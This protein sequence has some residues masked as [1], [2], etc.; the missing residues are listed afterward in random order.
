LI[1]VIL[2]TDPRWPIARVE[3]V[4]AGAATTLGGL[5][6]FAVQLRDKSATPER[7]RADALRL[8]ALT[9]R[10]GARLVVNA[11]TPAHLAVAVDVGADGAHV[12]CTAPSI[13]RAREALGGAWISTPAHTRNDVAL[14][15]SSGADAALVS[16]IFHTPGKGSERGV[17]ALREARAC[18][19]G[20][21][22]ASRLRLYAL[23]GVDASRAA[24]CAEA[25]AD[26]VAVIRALLDA[27]DPEREAELL[28]AP[29][30]RPRP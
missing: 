1:T 16:P 28:D 23:G 19:E 18:V 17:D 13:A 10:V 7:L 15:V 24:S 26:G 12:P 3:E 27:C 25:G 4:V 21:G 8:R 30:R 2:V 11:A 20:R 22:N 29:F 14:A 5:G 6:C 9:S